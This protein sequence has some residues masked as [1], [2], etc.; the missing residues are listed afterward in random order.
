MPLIVVVVIPSPTVVLA[1]LPNHQAV[2]ALVFAIAVTVP[3]VAAVGAAPKTT[4]V[5]EV[6]AVIGPNWPYSFV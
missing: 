4:T 1:L 2:T 6:N 3:L 5:V